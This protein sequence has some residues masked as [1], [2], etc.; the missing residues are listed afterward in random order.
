MQ[1]VNCIEPYDFW[2]GWDGYEQSLDASA[3]LRSIQ[4]NY[5]PEW[6]SLAYSHRQG[7]MHKLVDRFVTNDVQLQA[8]FTTAEPEQGSDCFTFVD[9][10]RRLSEFARLDD[11]QYHNEMEKTYG[12]MWTG[13][14]TYRPS[15]DISIGHFMTDI[16]KM[17]E[18]IG[19]ES[20]SSWKVQRGLLETKGIS[21]SMKYIRQTVR[22]LIP[23]ELTVNEKSSRMVKQNTLCTGIQ[24]IQGFAM[25]LFCY[26]Y[27]RQQMILNMRKRG[28]E[29]PETAKWISYV[30]ELGRR[31]VDYCKCVLR[32][33]LFL[34][35][36]LPG[37]DE[38]RAHVPQFSVHVMDTKFILSTRDALTIT[39]GPHEG[40]H[41]Y[42]VKVSHD[43]MP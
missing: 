11:S 21:E 5:N 8:M 20:F 34:Y 17:M 23:P 42:V 38:Q 4:K 40:R 9:T 30:D 22:V 14:Y 15:A 6:L 36:G 3:I 35:D 19:G 28:R 12:V 13:Y 32:P 2:E 24:I 25:F 41:R 16:V 43:S 31:F 37:S 33:L 27:S 10:T 7:G 39:V 1:A 26:G 29:N 18:T